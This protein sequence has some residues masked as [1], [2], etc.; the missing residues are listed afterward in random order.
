[1]GQ[2]ETPLPT[3]C[4]NSTARKRPRGGERGRSPGEERWEGQTTVFKVLYFCSFFAFQQN[5]NLQM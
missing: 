4:S 3:P 5:N 2:A 1:M